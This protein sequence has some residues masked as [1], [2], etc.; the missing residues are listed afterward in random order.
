MYAHPGRL[1][2]LLFSSALMIASAFAGNGRYVVILSAPSA[3]EQTKTAAAP[4][5]GR[6]ASSMIADA[7]RQIESSQLG[8]RGAIEARGMKVVAASQAVL[9]ALFVETTPDRVN[10]LR[11]MPGVA[12]V[13]PEK[14]YRLEGANSTFALHNV[15]AGWGQVGGESAAGDGIKIAFL[16]TGIDQ[17][18]PALQDPTLQMPA[19]F[20]KCTGSDCL[21]TTNKVIVARSYVANLNNCIPGNCDPTQTTPDDDSPRDRMGH[22]TATSTTAAGIL[23]TGPEGSIEGIAP[24]AYVGNYKIFG[25]PGTIDFSGDS[26]IIP[27]LDDAVKDGMDVVNMSLGGAIDGPITRDPEVQAVGAAVSAGVVVVVAA[28]NEADTGSNA[29]SL[30]T[31]GSPGDAPWAIT[32]GAID[33]S[34]S[35]TYFSSRGPS[36]A[37]GSAKP[38]L[39]ALGLN[40]Y[41]ATQSYDPNGEMY[42]PSRFTTASGTSFSTPIVAGAAALVKQA[43]A[44]YTPLE[45]KSALVNTA[46]PIS[47]FASPVGI[48]AGTLNVGQAIAS[49]VTVV[50][51]SVSF[52]N[53]TGAALPISYPLTI[54]NRSSGNLTL[55]ASVQPEASS[56]GAQVQASLS[57]STIAAGQ[58]AT[59]TVSLTGSSP[60]PGTYY[61]AV[62]LNGGSVPLRVPYLFVVTNAQPANVINLYGAPFSFTDQFDG[63]AGALLPNPPIAVRVTDSNGLPV[64][65]LRVQF[66][67]ASG[68]GNILDGSQT[69]DSSG[70]AG[71]SEVQLGPD[72]GQQEFQASVPGVPAVTFIGQAHLGPSIN[73]NG[74][75]DAATFSDGKA[76]SPGSYVAIIGGNLTPTPTPTSRTTTYLPLNING[77]NV[78]FDVPA[79]GLSYPGRVSYISPSQIN[80]ELPWELQNAVANGATSTDVKVLI[81]Y[82]FDTVETSV[83]TLPLAAYNPGF[84]QYNSGG[85]NYVAALDENN[86]L[87]GPNNP[88]QPGHVI[89][90]FA[91]GLGPVDQTIASGDPAPS[92][93]KVNTT[94]KPT[95]TINGESAHVDFSGLSPGSVSLYQIN[96]TV[97]AD[98]PAGAENIQISIGG[99][100]SPVST[101]MVQ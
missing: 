77:V 63:T 2:G 28:G 8:V 54:T 55:S 87:V 43:H 16:D 40:L 90:L 93:T 71:P 47:D 11:G 98:I 75:K 95:V 35:V 25:S 73:A 39:V 101:V 41:L 84:F 12:D 99:A 80:V 17:T 83:Y 3:I 72:V 100:T 91:N 29:V 34:N 67:A 4:V 9:N 33:S 20:P 45:I 66:S 56:A 59:L 92:N 46:V 31:I 32:V 23:T 48:G 52:G 37:D 69:T 79:Q 62:A 78:T 97:P 15:L 42:D 76:V 26:A 49:N 86:R 65:N 85:T 22:G 7:A 1:T 64:P 10:E 89:Q 44:E 36:T 70:V 68:G 5:R 21:Y 19:G 57:G 14:R 30:G 53:I 60:G 74:I 94:Q 58:T 96:V 24:K 13:I 27:A 81:N 61:G 6:L 18:H 82:N 51:S 38:D 50:P 88:V